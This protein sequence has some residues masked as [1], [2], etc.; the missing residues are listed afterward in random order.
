MKNLGY[1]FLFACIVLSFIGCGSKQEPPAATPEPLSESNIN[2]L[3]R[4]QTRL[5]SEKPGSIN[6]AANAV[7]VA[8]QGDS[9]VVLET[10]DNWSKIQHVIS[11]RIGWVNNSFIQIEPRNKSWYGDTDKSRAFA[12]KLS[13]DKLI[14]DRNWPIVFIGIEERW[15]KAT[16]SLKED[17]KFQ[18]DQAA[19][20]ATYV[21][22][23]LQ[24]EF[25]EWRDH[26]AFIEAV[27]DDGRYLLAMS[28]NKIAVFL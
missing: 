8:N 12:E 10:K 17:L 23:K 24:K 15:N 19:E 9:I 3:L 20:C 16:F 2:T 27:S 26:Q 18:K 4:G 5:L 21:I 13:K 22:E 25:P 14:A 6:D 11:G 7:S 1:Y 28:D